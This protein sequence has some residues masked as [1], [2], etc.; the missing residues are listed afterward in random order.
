VIRAQANNWNRL[1]E[2]LQCIE[3]DDHETSTEVGHH[4]E[5]RN[6]MPGRIALAGSLCEVAD[7]ALVT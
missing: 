4:G 6:E 5:M 3:E 2:K 1:F 7:Q